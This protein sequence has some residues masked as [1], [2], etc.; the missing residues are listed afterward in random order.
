[1]LRVDVVAVAVQLLLAEVAAAAE[2][3]EGHQHAVADLQ[4]LHRRANLLHNAAE[5]VADDR[6]D[7]GVGHEAVVDVDVRTADAGAG[8][9]H[10]GVVRMLDLRF[11]DV[12]DA[13]GARTA[14]RGG[15]HGHLRGRRTPASPTRAPDL[16]A[17]AVKAARPR[18]GRA[19][20]AATCKPA[21][22]A[23]DALAPRCE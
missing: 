5:L 19:V 17:C 10:D 2:D 3:V 20:D 11:G 9:A 15:Q 1:G 22:F 14:V 8:D 4:V 7:P 21:T 16:L 23:A 18:R 12:R 6:A 13:H